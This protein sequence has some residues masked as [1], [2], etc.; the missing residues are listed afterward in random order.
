MNKKKIIVKIF[1]CLF[2]VVALVACDKEPIDN[3]KTIP[4][5]EKETPKE[6]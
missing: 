4:K 2:A 6:I 1:C 5:E 3:G